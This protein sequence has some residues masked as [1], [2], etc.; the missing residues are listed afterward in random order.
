MKFLLGLLFLLCAATAAEESARQH[1]PVPGPFEHC[2]ADADCEMTV[3]LCGC[4]DFIA[5]NKK[6]VKKYAALEKY[7]KE[8]VPPCSCASPGKVPKCIQK[9]CRLVPKKS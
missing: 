3:T 5:M 4:C 7:C 9:L 1:I 8:P 2:K 6:F